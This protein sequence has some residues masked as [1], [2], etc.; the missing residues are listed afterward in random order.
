MADVAILEY[1]GQLYIL[2]KKNVKN[3]TLTSQWKKC[4][5]TVETQPLMMILELRTAVSSRKIQIT[6]WMV[7][8]VISCSSTQQL[9][10]ARKQ[11]QVGNYFSS[12]SCSIW[13]NCYDQIITFPLTGR[14]NSWNSDTHGQTI[15]FKGTVPVKSILTFLSYF[16]HTSILLL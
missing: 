16:Y 1:F 8:V 5:Q 13:A 14:L 3:V 7:L 9:T 6:D 12:I 15:A 2:Q 10:L 11:H 4:L